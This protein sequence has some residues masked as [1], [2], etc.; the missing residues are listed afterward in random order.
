MVLDIINYGI[1]PDIFPD[2]NWQEEILN[3]N[4]LRQSYYISARGGAKVAKYFLSLGGSNETAAYKYD[5][6]SI[7][8]S[9]VGYNTYTYRANIDLDLSRSTILYFGMDGFLSI[10]NQPGVAS[11]DY[12]WQAQSQINPLTLPVIYSNGQYPA[13]G[14]AEMTS[15]STMINHMGRRSDQKFDGK[16]T[17]AL[18]QDLSMWLEGLKLRVQGAYD[19]G[20]W[21]NENRSIQPELYQA[22]GRDGYGKLITILRVPS[23]AASYSKTM[24]LNRKYH[25]ESTL[26]YE[27]LFGESHRVSG[28]VYYYMSDFKRASEGTTNLNSIPIRYQGLSSRLTYGYRDTYMVDVNFG[29]TGSENFQPGR[30]FGFS[31]PS[32]SDG[33]QPNTNG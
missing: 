31:H 1:D 11:T 7:Y 27:N 19:I 5:K 20:S 4:S 32:R 22:V 24:D 16:F 18:N 10:H 17:L 33:Y 12:I 2:V 23:R 21:F 28:L 26:S 3:P 14:A 9:N 6:S 30:Q 25:L 15:P 13:V 8:G 29:Y